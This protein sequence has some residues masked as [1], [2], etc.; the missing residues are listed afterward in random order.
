MDHFDSAWDRL[1]AIGKCDTRGGAEYRRVRQ[2]WDDM[3]KQD[4]PGTVRAVEVLII[5][6]ANKLAD[7]TY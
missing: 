6:E 3:R 1:A 7:D 4:R 5:R 2:K